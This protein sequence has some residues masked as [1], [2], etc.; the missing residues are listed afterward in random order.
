M[1][2]DLSILMWIFFFFPHTFTSTYNNKKIFNIDNEQQLFLICFRVQY[3]RL[4]VF[5]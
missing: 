3:V 1:Y 2:N 4:R 5:N